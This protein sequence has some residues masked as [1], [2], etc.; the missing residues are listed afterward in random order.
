[1]GGNASNREMAEIREYLARR[2]LGLHNDLQDESSIVGNFPIV[3]LIWMFGT[4]AQREEFC[5]AGIVGDRRIGFGL[6]EPEHGSD[7]TWMKTR[8]TRDGESWVISGEKRWNT[9]LHTATHDLIF[10]RTSGKD[11]SATG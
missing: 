1:G 2:G 6:T 5:E 4:T 10:A 7:A 11:G 9:G 3:R 8:A